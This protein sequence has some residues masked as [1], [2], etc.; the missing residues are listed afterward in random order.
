MNELS[1]ALNI[2]S[3]NTNY[4]TQTGVIPTVQE[5]N[6]RLAQPNTS[7]QTTITTPSP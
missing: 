6:Y 5:S 3:S 7:T 4:F 2:N 1:I